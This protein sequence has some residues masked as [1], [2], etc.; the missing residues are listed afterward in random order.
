MTY[1]YPGEDQ[2]VIATTSIFTFPEKKKQE[3]Q[4]KIC[5]YLHH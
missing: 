2:P 5:D 4:Q 3:Q 1:N